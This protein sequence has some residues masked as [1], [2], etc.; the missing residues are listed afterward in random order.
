[1]CPFSNLNVILLLYIGFKVFILGFHAHRLDQKRPHPWPCTADAAKGKNQSGMVS[2]FPG[3][4]GMHAL[5]HAVQ[6]ACS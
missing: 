6:V 3:W 2:S 1:M 4:H 5:Q